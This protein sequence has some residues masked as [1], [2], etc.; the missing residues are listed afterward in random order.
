MM[1]IVI[2]FVLSVVFMLQACQEP[3]L[4]GAWNVTKIQGHSLVG[5][6]QI[7]LQFTQDKRVFGS[8]GCNQYSGVLSKQAEAFKVEQLANTRRACVALVMQ[9]ETEFLQ[10]LT[11][12][13]VY[14]QKAD[15]LTLYNSNGERVLELV[16]KQIDS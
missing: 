5:N 13:L 4:S 2:I 12:T 15:H 16:A 7:S 1:K 6:S 9:Q 14:K 11:Q 8:A 3:A 10:L